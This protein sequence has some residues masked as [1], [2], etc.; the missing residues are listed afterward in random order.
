MID[1]TNKRFDEGISFPPLAEKGQRVSVANGDRLFEQRIR[2]QFIYVKEG[3]HV[4]I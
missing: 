2:Q 4:L 1:P 3:L